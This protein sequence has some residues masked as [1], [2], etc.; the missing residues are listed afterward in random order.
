MKQVKYFFLARMIKLFLQFGFLGSLI[1][2]SINILI[3][4]INDKPS[5]KIG[6][7]KFGDEIPGYSLKAALDLSIPDTISNYKNGTVNTYKYNR[8]V[9]D[10]DFSKDSLNEQT[11]NKF[12]TFGSSP[13]IKVENRIIANN[14]LVRV[15]SN[16]N[17]HNFFWL[18][19]SQMDLI[20]TALF[21]LLF[22]KLTN[23]YMDK[24]IFEA[25]SF[26]LVSFLGFL[27]II[28]EVIAFM[29]SFINSEIISAASL[30]TTS[31][32][33]EK[34]YNYIGL[35]LNFSVEV[36]YGNIGVG[37]I[38]I[39]L[40]QVLKQAILLKQEQALTI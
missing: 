18:I 19:S 34:T 37:I 11:A 15:R 21:C 25:R 3:F 5:Y 40:A 13:D 12:I 26:K 36:D 28:R 30:S 17:F 38:V 32:I 14:V 7:F 39:L 2:I 16:H 31:T 4:I 29:I 27:L 8:Y 1:G 23:R 20:F 6:A 35:N 22:I 24:D 33:S 10:K 9:Y